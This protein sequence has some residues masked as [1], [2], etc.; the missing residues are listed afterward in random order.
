MLDVI[1]QKSLRDKAFVGAVV[2]FVMS[3]SGVAVISA[4]AFEILVNTGLNVLQASLA[5]DATT[6]VSVVSNRPE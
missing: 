4:F 3:F 1:Q 5:N 6:I 2:T